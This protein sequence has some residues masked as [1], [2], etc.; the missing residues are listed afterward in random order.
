MGAEFRPGLGS[1]G[2]RGASEGLAQ[3]RSP[4]RHGLSTGSRRSGSWWPGARSPGPPGR[5]RTPSE[6]RQPV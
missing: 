5:A 2:S 1:L 3:P 4:F 6:R